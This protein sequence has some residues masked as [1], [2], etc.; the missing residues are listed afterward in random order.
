MPMAILTKYECFEAL[1]GAA[2]AA[3]TTIAEKQK[4]AAETQQAANILSA[5][6]RQRQ[7]KDA[8]K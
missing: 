8:R 6:R 4:L 7:Q 2:N 1:K 5:L 3:A